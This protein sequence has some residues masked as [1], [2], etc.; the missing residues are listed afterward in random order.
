M[1]TN[2][3]PCKRSYVLNTSNL[4]FGMNVF[5]VSTSGVIQGHHGPLISMPGVF[6][7]LSDLE[8]I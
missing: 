8:V 7:R 6:L 5:H 3:S 2:F 4:M 1:A